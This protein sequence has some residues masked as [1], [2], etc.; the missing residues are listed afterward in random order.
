MN[1]K[2]RPVI[3]VADDDRDI[4]EL[5]KMQL[6]RHGFD[7]YIAEDGEVAMELVNQHQPAVALLDIMMPKLS[8]LEVA[9]RIRDDPT[10]STVSIMLISARS[11]GRIEA[12]LED[13]NI[14]DYITKPFSPQDLVQ[15][16]NEVINHPPT[17][18]AT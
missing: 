13:L 10:T 12:D 3:V 16:I 14:A 11:S 6:T 7:V 4:C 5:I 17:E 2:K 18:R 8:G 1:D 9:R 15:R